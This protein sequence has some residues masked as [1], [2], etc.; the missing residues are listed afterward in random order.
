M[1]P[2]Q[3]KISAQGSYTVMEAARLLDIDRRTLRRYEAAGLVPA[4]LNGLGRRRHLGKDLLNLWLTC[5]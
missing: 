2:T 5:Y 1:I 4:H 3:P